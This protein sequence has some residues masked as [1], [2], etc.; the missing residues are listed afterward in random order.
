MSFSRLKELELDVVEI[1]MLKLIW[2][3]IET[4]QKLTIESIKDDSL[5]TVQFDLKPSRNIKELILRSD[6]PV[7]IYRQLL[8]ATPE[9]RVLRVT[10]MTARMLDTI[11]HQL[12][13]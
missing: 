4:V 1:A 8:E 2:R 11:S 9:L 10:T 13:T 5:V 12:L 6:V 7:N 3:N